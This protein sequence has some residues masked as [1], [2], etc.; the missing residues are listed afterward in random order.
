MPTAP[1]VDA[2][3]DAELCPA[4]HHPLPAHAAISTRWCAATSLGIG[5]RDCLCSREV[6]SARVLRH[7]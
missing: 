7:Y 6:S 3:P 4:C 5:H 2:V 1:A